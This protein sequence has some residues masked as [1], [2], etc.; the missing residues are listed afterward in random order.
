MK[1]KHILFDFD[2]TLIDTNKVFTNANYKIS[3]II[4]KRDKKPFKEVSEDFSKATLEAHIKFHVNPE[5]EWPE[6]IRIFSQKYELSQIQKEEIINILNS[7]YSTPVETFPDTIDT[8]KNLKR[9]GF[10]LYL[11]THASKEYTDFKLVNSK[12]DKYIKD[13]FLVSVDEA[14]GVKHWKEA[15]KQ[16]NVNPKECIAVGDNVKG[17]II[18]ADEVGI[19]KKFWFDS[20]S[21]WSHYKEG[22]LPKGTIIIHTLNE[23]LKYI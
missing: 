8:L 23:I 5:K 3:K 20:K 1:Y 17:D 11:V 4:S 2:D 18:S 6:V 14:K 22:V 7:I 10:N 9:L 19:E 21:G 12:I 13:I 15:L 16:F